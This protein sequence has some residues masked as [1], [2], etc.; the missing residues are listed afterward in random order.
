MKRLV[1][2]VMV[3][4]LGFGL[5]GCKSD[6]AKDVDGYITAIGEIDLA[7]GPVLDYVRNTYEMLGDEDKAMTEN[8]EQL[9]LA[10]AAYTDLLIDAV[11]EVTL[12]SEPAIAAA[13]EVYEGLEADAKS[14]V[15]G[16]AKLQADRAAFDRKALIHALSGVWVNELMG[17]E[18]VGAA[19]IGRGLIRNFGLDETNC[20]PVSKKNADNGQNGLTAVDSRH[21]ELREDGVLIYASLELGAWEVSEDGKKVTLNVEYAADDTAVYTLN[22][23]EEAGF[24]KLVGA[25]FENQPFGYVK[26]EKYLEAF[27]QKF[28]V[29]QLSKD[30]I[31]DYI[32]DPVLIGQ[33]LSNDG[34]KY[35]A[36]VYPS[37]MYEQGF[38]YLGSSCVIQVDYV[39][40]GTPS[41]FWLDFPVLSMTKLKMKDVKINTESRLSGEIYYIK[42]DFVEKNYINEDGFRVLALTNGVTMVF[43]GYSDAINT[44]WNRVEADYKDYMY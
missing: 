6:A 26:E 7:S 28:Q 18:S 27:H 1:I 22:V 12:D 21:F 39:H 37:K 30:N 10:E 41:Y 44:F 33:L 34:K 36:Y 23:M 5:F 40:G 16:Y 32:D 29:A 43:D 17:Y 3:C 20:N 42:E 11:G 2:L 31:H 8:Y 25:V 13:E 19:K 9:L 24:T 14:K 38:V 35:N 4:I 15:A